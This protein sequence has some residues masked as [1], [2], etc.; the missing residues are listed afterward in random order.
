MKSMGSVYEDD[1]NYGP[2][3]KTDFEPDNDVEMKDDGTVDWEV[4]LK[5]RVDTSDS[6]VEQEME[7]VVEKYNGLVSMK[8]APIIVGCEKHDIDLVE[9]VGSLAN[10][11]EKIEIENIVYEMRSFDL[12][13]SIKEVQEEFTKP[14]ADWRVTNVVIADSSGKTQIP[15]W[16][17]A[18]DK[19][20]ELNI[21]GGYK[22]EV[23]VE[24][25]YTKQGSE[26]RDF[27]KQRYD[28][29]P[30]EIGDSTTVTI[31]YP[32]GEEEQVVG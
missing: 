15:L 24:G 31:I 18:S 12:H 27:H 4:E 20:Q 16:N 21:K 9:E 14:D 32:D 10:A 1:E 19:I 22:E 30:I 13:A 5:K 6:E 23:K 2:I 25:A 7:A 29:P 3:D 26:V 28:A 11:M 8:S 17:E